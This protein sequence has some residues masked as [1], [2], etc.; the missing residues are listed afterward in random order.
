MRQ[1]E[2][3]HPQ[4]T[5][6]RVTLKVDDHN[7]YHIKSNTIKLFYIKQAVNGKRQIFYS[8]RNRGELFA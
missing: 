7:K 3:F 6:D 5:W 2:A 4:K 8:L 1:K